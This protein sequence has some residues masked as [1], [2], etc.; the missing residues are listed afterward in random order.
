MH[1][2]TIGTQKPACQLHTVEFAGDGWYWVAKHHACPEIG[3]CLGGRFTE[4]IISLNL[5]IYDKL[6]NTVYCRLRK[7]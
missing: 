3:A 1:I 5:C 6:V 7:T 4:T 2:L